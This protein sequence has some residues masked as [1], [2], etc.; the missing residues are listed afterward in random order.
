MFSH[1]LSSLVFY[2]CSRVVVTVSKRLEF[3][4]NVKPAALSG[5]CLMNL[6]T[7]ENTKPTDSCQSV[8]EEKVSSSTQISFY[9][10]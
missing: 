1:V 9:Q 10:D 4:N 8:K 3:T 5:L 7:D 6:H 2:V